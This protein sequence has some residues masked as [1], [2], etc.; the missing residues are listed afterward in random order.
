MIVKV[1]I[2]FL[3]IRTV[4]SIAKQQI[5]TAVF[6]RYFVSDCHLNIAAVCVIIITYTY[7]G[8]FSA[9]KETKEWQIPNQWDVT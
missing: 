2:N 7:F 9:E 8:G 6:R 3:L 1:I 5:P 4:I